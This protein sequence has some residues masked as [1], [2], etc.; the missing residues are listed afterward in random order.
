MVLAGPPLAIFDLMTW[1]ELDANDESCPLIKA[2]F[3]DAA[4]WGSILSTR[5]ACFQPDRAGS[6]RWKLG[7]EAAIPPLTHI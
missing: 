6:W 3:K 7:L 1:Q 2:A 5:I 4:G